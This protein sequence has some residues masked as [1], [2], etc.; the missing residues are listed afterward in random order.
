MKKLIKITALAVALA[1]AGIADARPVFHPNLGCING[2]RLVFIA[3]WPRWVA[4]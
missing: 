2:H 3:G 4:C 1:T